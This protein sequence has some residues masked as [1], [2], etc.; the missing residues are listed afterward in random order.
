VPLDGQLGMSVHP[1]AR[2]AALG[3]KLEMPPT[4]AV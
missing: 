4:E 2:S 3:E 1:G